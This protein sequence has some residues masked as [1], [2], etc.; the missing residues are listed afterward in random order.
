MVIGD[1]AATAFGCATG[2]ELVETTGAA[3]LVTGDALESD[4][5]KTCGTTM[6]AWVAAGFW[7]ASAFAAGLGDA[8]LVWTGAGIDSTAEAAGTLRS[9]TAPCCGGK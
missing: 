9:G 2:L 8:L 4:A 5:L 1:G 3:L 7:P 6:P